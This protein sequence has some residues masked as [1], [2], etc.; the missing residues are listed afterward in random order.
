MKIFASLLAISF[1]PGS[2]PAETKLKRVDAPARGGDQRYLA[3]VSTDKPIY[4]EGEKVYLRSVL[5]HVADRTPY[6][7]AASAFVTIK[8]PKGDQAFQ[9]RSTLEDAVTGLAW[10]VPMGQA[11]GEY[12]VSVVY[13][14]VGAPPAE[15]K[16]AVRAYRA[17][18]LKTQIKFLR[19]GYGPGDEAVATLSANRAEYTPGPP[20]SASTSRQE[21]SAIVQLLVIL[22]A[23]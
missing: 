10:E 3:H 16:F 2:A 15:R 7:D 23:A 8:G 20:P 9:T 22:A 17:P 18:R 5:L 4:R 11:G 1:L 12:T 19:D 14:Q 13:P 21:S 6:S